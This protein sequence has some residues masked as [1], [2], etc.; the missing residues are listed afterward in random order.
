M[1]II[2]NLK[3]I[4]ILMKNKFMDEITTFQI[5]HNVKNVIDLEETSSSGDEIVNIESLKIDEADIQAFQKINTIKEK[6]HINS[7]LT[8]IISKG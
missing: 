5:N 7:L 1:K 3:D 6:E 8:G 2:K 4:K